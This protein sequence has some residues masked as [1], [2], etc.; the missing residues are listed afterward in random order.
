LGDTEREQLGVRSGVT[1]TWYLSTLYWEL[2][3]EF[4]LRVIFKFS[5]TELAREQE[6]NR[7]GEGGV[8]VSK[9]GNSE[10]QLAIKKHSTFLLS[11]LFMHSYHNYPF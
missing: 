7:M 5:P 10:S 6:L 9:A 4:Q 8:P 3:D 2:K 11:L 1:A